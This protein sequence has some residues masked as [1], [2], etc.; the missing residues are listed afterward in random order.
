MNNPQQLK[1]SLNTI[2]ELWDEYVSDSVIHIIY[3]F[4]KQ[5]CY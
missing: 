3:D 1:K 4:V 5:K 2:I